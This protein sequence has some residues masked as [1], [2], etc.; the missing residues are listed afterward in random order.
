MFFRGCEQASKN[1]MLDY[2]KQKPKALRQTYTGTAETQE[3]EL[4]LV[5]GRRGKTKGK[6]D[7]ERLRESRSWLVGIGAGGGENNILYVP[8]Q[9]TVKSLKFARDLPFLK[10]FSSQK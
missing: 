7:R 2:A 8:Y 3:A 1:R 4:R 5:V 9:R 10:T 6:I